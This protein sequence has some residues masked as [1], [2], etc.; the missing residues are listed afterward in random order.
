MSHPDSADGNLHSGFKS[1]REC[2]PTLTTLEV[3]FGELNQEN[4]DSS[5]VHTCL[6]Y[7]NHLE[8][9]CFTSGRCNRVISLCSE[10]FP[11]NTIRKLLFED[12]KY[13]KE[14]LEEI[15]HLF[16]CLKEI[17]IIS[18]AKL[19]MMGHRD[20][21]FDLNDLIEHLNIFCLI[22][23]L[24]CLEIKNVYSTKSEDA[25]TIDEQLKRVLRIVHAK[26][27]S[28][29]ECRIPIGSY[30]TFGSFVEI[31]KEKGVGPVLKKSNDV[32]VY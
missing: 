6:T 21:K 29:F 10:P 15:V 31:F 20:S 32:H 4:V 1:L 19:G 9:V 2:C 5:L 23:N 8:K 3:S 24:H 11:K 30:G 14:H 18:S 13:D 25:Q 27:S 16:P 17:K 28:N 7:F 26:F 22:K 12:M